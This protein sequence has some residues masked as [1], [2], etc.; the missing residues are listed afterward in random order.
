MTFGP[1]SPPPNSELSKRV[2]SRIGNEGEWGTTALFCLAWLTLIASV[3]VSITLM[4]YTGECDGWG[5]RCSSFTESHSLFFEGL[6]IGLA[7]VLQAVVILG[8]H[9]YMVA[10]RSFAKNLGTG[11]KSV[12][13]KIEDLA[14]TLEGMK[15][16][17]ESS[18]DPEIPEENDDENESSKR[19]IVGG[20]DLRLQMQQDFERRLKDS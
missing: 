4:A 17:L 7:G 3:I 15:S 9:S 11:L 16:K 14:Q 8:I 20:R 13:M 19:P 6:F 18:E 2:L 1:G 10:Q 5:G 12:N